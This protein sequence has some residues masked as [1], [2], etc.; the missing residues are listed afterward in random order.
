MND[1]ETMSEQHERMMGREKRH[2]RG[3]VVC[4]GIAVAAWLLLAAFMTQCTGFAATDEYP[5]SDTYTVYAGNPDSIHGFL[6]WLGIVRTA[7]AK[8]VAVYCLKQ[9]M[10]PLG[11]YQTPDGKRAIICVDPNEIMDADTCVSHDLERVTWDAHSITCKR[12]SA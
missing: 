4:I 8:L 3:F 5:E 12:K 2:Y 11:I 7:P 10:L 9:Q 1:P 6:T